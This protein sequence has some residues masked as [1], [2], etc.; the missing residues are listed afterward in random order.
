M[1]SLENALGRELLWRPRSLLSRTYD[2][3]DG[4]AEP[5]EPYATLTTEG[6]LLAPPRA[7]GETG[8]GSWLFRPRGFFRE[9]VLVLLEGSDSPLAVFRRHWRRGVLRFEGGKEFVWRRPSFWSLSWA[10][11]DPG[12]ARA[13]RFSTRL[14]FP[15]AST[16]VEL[17]PSVGRGSDAPL[18]VCLGWYLLLLA[19]RRR[20]GTRGL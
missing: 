16:R 2:L 19:R 17:D 11:E 3:V 13:V 20:A 10:F 4:E 5:G 7:H 1:R 15:R 6:G 8:A 18:L 12:G 9:R 14:S